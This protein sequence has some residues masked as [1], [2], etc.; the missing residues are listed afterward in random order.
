MASEQQ[1]VQ[2]QPFAG[3]CKTGVGQSA[4]PIPKKG[5]LPSTTNLFYHA[6]LA[7]VQWV[8]GRSSGRDKTPGDFTESVTCAIVCHAV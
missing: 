1:L 3:F 5:L 7:H 6:E 2:V 4:L 8:N